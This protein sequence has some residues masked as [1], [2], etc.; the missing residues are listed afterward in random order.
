ME[1]NDELKIAINTPFMKYIVTKILSKAIESKIGYK[2]DIHLNE[3]KAETCDG[4]VTLHADIDAIT[5]TGELSKL[6]ES[7]GIM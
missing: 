5:T 6:L 2:I 7:K 1:M 4:M 3:I